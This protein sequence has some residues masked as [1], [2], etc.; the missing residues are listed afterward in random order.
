MQR[1]RGFTSSKMVHITKEISKIIKLMG[2]VFSNLILY[3]IREILRIASFTGQES[4]IKRTLVSSNSQEFTTKVLCRMARPLGLKN[5]TINNKFVV[6]TK[7]NLT[8]MANFQEKASTK[9]SLGD[10]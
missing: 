3:I 7:D 6:S 8:Q 9:I 4:S 10:I 1:V 5:M 2:K